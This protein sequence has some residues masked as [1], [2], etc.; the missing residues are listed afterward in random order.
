MEFSGDAMGKTF[1]AF[2]SA[3]M[4]LSVTAKQAK[5]VF[6]SLRVCWP[7][8]HQLET[9]TSAHRHA[10]VIECWHDLETVRSR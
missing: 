10:S 2:E 9:T 6:F 1:D 4:S 8:I 5:E 3:Q 7:S